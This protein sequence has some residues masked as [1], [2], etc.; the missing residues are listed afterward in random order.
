M[1]RMQYSEVFNGVGKLKTKQVK[2]HIDPEVE[3]VA[4][5]LRRTPFNLRKKVEDKIK[6][7][8]EMDILEES[9]LTGQPPGEPGCYCSQI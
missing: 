5:L 9:K 7:L 3:P 2:L 6:E 4:Q 8:V 1:L